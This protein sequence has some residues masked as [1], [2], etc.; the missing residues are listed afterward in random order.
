VGLG[1]EPDWPGI[2]PAQDPDAAR[3]VA[4][5]IPGALTSVESRPGRERGYHIDL[6]PILDDPVEC[7]R[8]VQWYVHKL[9]A[10]SIKEP[11]RAPE[12][13]AVIDKAKNRARGD[14]VGVLRL[15]GAISI[16]FKR[17][18]LII[19][20]SKDEP[21]AR[22][23]SR[24]PAELGVPAAER[25]AGYNVALV[26]DHCTTGSEA[27]DALETIEG[28]GGTVTIFLAYTI[29]GSEFRRKDFEAKGVTVKHFLSAPEDLR[30][31]GLRVSELERLG[32]SVS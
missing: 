7:D 14:T 15:A 2:D 13:L 22:L 18:H 16:A 26:T 30:L 1:I 23:K 21:A 17:P 27:L 9:S 24:A 28:N 6:D 31:I 25:F 4:F 12:L 11:A 29:I 8:V 10:F 19:D 5:R 3:R 20:M 32:L